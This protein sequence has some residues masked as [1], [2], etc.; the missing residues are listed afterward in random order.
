MSGIV[1]QS[2][3]TVVAPIREGQE[4][5]LD[6][7]LRGL[8]GRTAGGVTLAL[9][10]VQSLHF[11]RFVILPAVEG[12]DPVPP[13]LAFESNYDGSLDDH[14]D[15]LYAKNG[16]ALDRIFSHCQGY[17]GGSGFMEF[18]KR[19][20]VPSAAYY[21]AHAGLGVSQIQSDAAVRDAIEAWLDSEQRAGRLEKLSPRE[22][23]RG[24]MAHLVDMRIDGQAP[25]LG[26]VERGL[27]HVPG[28]YFRFVL[29]LLGRAFQLLWLLL[30]AP[31]YERQDAEEWR[32]HPPRLVD[33]QDAVLARIHD[34]EDRVE[35]NGLTHLVPIKPGPYRH[36]TLRAALWIVSNVAR[37]L[38]VTGTL[39]GLSTI[40]FARW[41]LLDDDR[42]LF[43]SNYDGSWEAYLG[44][45]IDKVSPWLTV[46]WTNTKWFP[47]TRWLFFDGAAD[48][49]NFKHWT[50]TWQL[51][52][53]LWY[54][55][56]PRLSVDA[57]LANARIREGAVGELDDKALEQWIEEL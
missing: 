37:Y 8:R 45:F 40:H 50:R 42:V 49:R 39:G 7:L 47:P 41:A 29:A 25:V 10:K 26:H 43:F 14:L 2:A 5:Q 48:E 13:K 1:E 27:P 24:L 18:A 57:V 19:K 21:R 35:Q 33:N 11:G 6:A 38:A 23:R 9:H 56:Y 3:L 32:A 28:N 51:E 52:N 31:S 17:A 22:I 54:S 12:K 34:S 4:K 30:R 55:A 20:S 15:E 16:Q 36:A 44:D 46:V 53:Q